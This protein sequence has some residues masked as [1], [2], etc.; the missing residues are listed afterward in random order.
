VNTDNW[1]LTCNISYQCLAC[2]RW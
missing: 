2:I 1:L